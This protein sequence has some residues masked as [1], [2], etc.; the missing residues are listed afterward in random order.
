MYIYIYM[1]NPSL[2]LSL[3]LS[4]HTTCIWACANLPAMYT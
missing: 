3:S 4:P 1:Y 2:S